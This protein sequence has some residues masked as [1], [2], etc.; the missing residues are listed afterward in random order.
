MSSAKQNGR[1]SLTGSLTRVAIP[2]GETRTTNQ[3]AEDR[4]RG[5]VG[6]T[7]LWFRRRKH[8][9]PVVN[10]SSRGAMIDAEIEARIGETVELQFADDHRTRCVVRWI[11]EGKIGV[12]FVDETIFWHEFQLSRAEAVAVAAAEAGPEPKSEEAP[13][14]QRRC[15][16]AHRPPRHALMRMGTVLW[17]GM[18][19]PVRLRNISEGGAKL[20]SGRDLAPGTEVELNLGDAGFV[21]G[22]VRW[23]KD[24]QVG[25]CF[26]EDFDLEALAPAKGEAPPPMLKP[27]YLESE[28]DPDSPWAARFERLSLG[29]LPH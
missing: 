24:G 9:V 20:E 6:E 29:D 21:Y 23:S 25:V 2:R 18:V 12:E 11:R 10:V 8:V 26:V 5:I 27:Q 3:R 14:P 22:Q 13:P 16:G 28:T 4:H 19:L 1:V 15:T 7:L 17:N